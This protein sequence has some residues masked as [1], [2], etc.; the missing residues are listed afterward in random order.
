MRDI[1]KEMPDQM[2]YALLWFH[3]LLTATRTISLLHSSAA[4]QTIPFMAKMTTTH[5]FF[6][7]NIEKS[8]YSSHPRSISFTTTAIGWSSIHLKCPFGHF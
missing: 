2:P 4:V 5:R 7:K 6:S 3:I 8:A 1:R